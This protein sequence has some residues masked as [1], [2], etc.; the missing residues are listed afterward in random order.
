MEAATLT[1]GSRRLAS[2]AAPAGN[3]ARRGAAA[4]TAQRPGAKLPRRA[5]RLR[6]LPPELS[7]ILAPKLVPGSPA[8]TG[9]V[10]SL[11]PISAVMLLFYFVSNWVFP[12][13]VMR[14]MQPNAEDEAAAAEAESMGSS[15]Q[16][17]PGDAVGGKIRRKVKRKKNRKAVTEG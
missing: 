9:D 17:Q 4:A 7:E 1:I 12:A 6:A 16:P 13:V 2:A 11:I 15:S 10:S 8:D 14:G 5:R 3:G